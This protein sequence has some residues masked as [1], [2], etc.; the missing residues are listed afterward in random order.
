MAGSGLWIR[1]SD[2]PG[3]IISGKIFIGTTKKGSLLGSGSSNIFKMKLDFFINPEV[4]FDSL[5]VFESLY[6]HQL[7][8]TSIERI[9]LKDHGGTFIYLKDKDTGTWIAEWIIC[10]IHRILEDGLASKEFSKSVS[11]IV[12]PDKS[13]VYLCR[14]SVIPPYQ[15]KGIGKMMN[16]FVYGMGTALKVD[17]VIAH[18]RPGLSLKMNEGMGMKKLRVC[19]NWF[20]TGE[21]YTLTSIKLPQ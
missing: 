12:L 21:N 6:P 9:A 17:Y 7:K 8:Y 16:A 1:I 5:Q 2:F 4:P 10:S 11:G 18:L 13:Y 14:T 15:N 3:L 19:E 20:G